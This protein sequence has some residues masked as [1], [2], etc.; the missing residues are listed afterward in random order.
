MSWGAW[1]SHEDLPGRQMFGL[2]FEDDGED[3]TA[4]NADS[5]AQ[6]RSAHAEDASAHMR[7]QGGTKRCASPPASPPGTNDGGPAAR[8]SATSPPVLP[9]TSTGTSSHLALGESGMCLWYR[10]DVDAS[11]WVRLESDE[12]A[13][14][15]RCIALCRAQVHITRDSVLRCT[16]RSLSTVVCLPRGGS[17]AN[18]M[19]PSLFGAEGLVLRCVIPSDRTAGE[20]LQRAE[21][22]INNVLDKFRPAFFKIGITSN[23]LRR[24]GMYT[25]DAGPLYEKMYVL[26]FAEEPGCCAMLEAALI[27]L[28]RAAAGCHN[29]RPGGEGLDRCARAPFATYLVVGRA[30]R[31]GERRRG[32]TCVMIARSLSFSCSPARRWQGQ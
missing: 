3:G 11:E 10:R 20:V 17:V 25:H 5:S 22:M 15:D 18:R 27:R 2:M 4:S 19:D 7:S 32:K 28:F 1:Y 6:A 13:A 31:A 9:S 8:T 12:E 26:H 24:W 30:D 29:E 14:L 21:A 16:G 23:V